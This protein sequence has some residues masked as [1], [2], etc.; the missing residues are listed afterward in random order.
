[1]TG[2]HQ[3]LA[4]LAI[5][6]PLALGVAATP[7]SP[8]GHEVF[9]FDDPA[10]VEAS[11]LVVADGRFVTTND[12]GDTGRVFT[13]D[14]AGRTVGVTHWSGDPTDTEALA[15]GG[16]GFVWVGDIGDN[17]G[18]RASVEIARI[19]VGRGDRTVHPTTYRLTYPDG[20][21]DAETL[22]RDPASGRLY[23][24][25]KNVFGGVLYAVPVDL[26]AT[27]PNRLT[28]IGRVLPVA[29]DG[30]FFPD[31]RHLIVRN[32]S[33]AVVYAW[34]S[35]QPVGSFGLPHQQQGEGISVA[36]DGRIYVS[37]EGPHAPVLEV[38]LPPSLRAAVRPEVSAGPG[39][40]SPSASTGAHSS[41]SSDPSA[42]E[43]AGRDAWPYL[44]GGLLGVVALIVLLRALR[45]R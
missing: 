33:T 36:T 23:I 8:P 45:P 9:T 26:D 1:L 20:A 35:L 32:Y 24:A 25:S 16:P 28:S 15:P 31:G 43:P 2:V 34:P 37:S 38:S 13:V 7:P 22:L 18:R 12:S 29:T 39:S 30:S 5:A 4:G 42:S 10:I 6:A 11:A 17:L 3:L 40:S 14:R 21:T 44:M 41:E 27:R 19:P